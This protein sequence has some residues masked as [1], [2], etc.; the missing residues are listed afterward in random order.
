MKPFIAEKSISLINKMR[1]YTNLK[2]SSQRVFNKNKL[3]TH[4]IE[5]F[6]LKLN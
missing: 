1:R 6:Y 5:I 2:R 3:N 4:K